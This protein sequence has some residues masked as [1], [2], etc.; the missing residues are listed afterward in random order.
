MLHEHVDSIVVLKHTNEYIERYVESHFVGTLAGDVFMHFSG[1][2][3][4]QPSCYDIRGVTPAV[5]Y[6]VNNEPMSTLPDYLRE[7]HLTAANTVYDSYD[8]AEIESDS[9]KEGPDGWVPASRFEVYDSTTD[10]PDQFAYD[11]EYTETTDGQ[12]EHTQKAYPTYRTHYIS[13]S[14]PPSTPALQAYSSRLQAM[15]GGSKSTRYTRSAQKI[16][17]RLE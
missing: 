9:E 7:A 12:A 13:P 1:I 3:P 10:K 4:K 17:H 16:V 14:A 15:A 8:D 11:E 5:R 2:I 6:M